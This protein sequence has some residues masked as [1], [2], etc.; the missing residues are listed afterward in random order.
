MYK[1]CLLV[2]CLACA[3]AE[4]RL[5]KKATLDQSSSSQDVKGQKLLEQMNTSAGSESHGHANRSGSGQFAKSMFNPWRKVVPTFLAFF[6][7]AAGFASSSNGLVLNSR[8][9][10]NNGFVSNSGIDGNTQAPF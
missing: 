6:N 1:F 3:L 4:R 7:P 8:I 9:G 5:I 10:G 2:A